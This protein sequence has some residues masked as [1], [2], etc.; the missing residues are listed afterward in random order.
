MYRE[1]DKEDRNG[2]PVIKKDQLY[3]DSRLILNF[4]RS[5][6]KAFLVL[7]VKLMARLPSKVSL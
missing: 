5:S 1:C 7:K 3:N 6:Y 4:G 2:M